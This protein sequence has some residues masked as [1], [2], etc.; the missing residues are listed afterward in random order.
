MKPCPPDVNTAAAG[1]DVLDAFHRETLQR[2]DRL[3]ALVQALGRDAID[4]ATPAD[5]RG[6]VDF[7]TGPGREHNADEERHVFPVLKDCEDPEAVRAVERLSE[8]HAWIEMHWLDVQ[9][10]LEAW[11]SGSR[12]FRAVALREAADPFLALSRGHIAAEERLLYP[13]AQ[14]RMTAR[15]A[16]S[17]ARDLASKTRRPG[18]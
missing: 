6:L 16:R 2:L 5:V 8:E 10:Q 15:E 1:F 12:T 13:Q 14:A 7:F 4:G 17:M 18:R 11:L 3:E 9:A